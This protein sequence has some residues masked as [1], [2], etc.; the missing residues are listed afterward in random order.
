[1]QTLRPAAIVC[2][3]LSSGGRASPLIHDLDLLV[4]VGARL[5]IVGEPDD[6]PSRLLRILAGLSSAAA[7][8]VM[9]AGLSRPEAHSSGWAR[10]VA[11]VGPGVD[12]PAW[13]TPRE[14][15]SL[16]A[17]LLGV[18]RSG[19]PPLVDRWLDEVRIGREKDQPIRRG[20]PAVAQ[21]VG[22]ATALLG[23]PEVLLLDEPL[24]A[25]DP[26]ERT[27]LLLLPDRRRTTVIASRYPSSEEGLVNR[28]ALVRDGQVAI[29]T[30]VGALAARGLPLTKRGIATLA[31]LAP[32]RRPTATV[33]FHALGTS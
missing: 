33:A 22:L 31:D 15:L 18:A 25:L 6:A 3:K 16:G 24:R 14:A 1:M 11:Y 4:P 7:G 28:I 9:L 20:G 12:A 26:L 32:D 13:L 10:R 27:R 17:R 29:H 5:L 30:G 23:G 21:R 2:R 8:S 19:I